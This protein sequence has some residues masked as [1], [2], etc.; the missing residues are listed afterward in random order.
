L[1]PGRYD[2]ELDKDG[3][4]FRP[5]GKQA[6]T[7]IPPAFGLAGVNLSTWTGFG[8]VTYWNAYVAGTQMHGAATFYDTRFDNKDQYPVSAKSGSGETRNTPDKTTAIGSAALLPALDSRA[9]GAG[10]LIR[11]GCIRTWQDALQWPGEVRDLPR[12]AAL[13]GAGAEL[14]YARGN[15]HRFVPGRA[16]L[17]MF[18]GLF[19]LRSNAIG[20]QAMQVATWHIMAMSTVWICFLV[21]MLL[22][23]STELDYLTAKVGAVACAVV[24]FLLMAIGAWLG[25]RLVYEFGVAVKEPTKS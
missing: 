20:S 9:E 19:D 12:P 1:G 24:G 21:A 22:S 7:L 3:K 23:I 16:L 4:A 25:G 17:A 18:A 14:A 11:Q 2:A 5:E 8:S 6:G 13:Y 15:R 10:W